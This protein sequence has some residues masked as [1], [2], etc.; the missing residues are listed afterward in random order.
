MDAEAVEQELMEYSALHA[1]RD[2]L[3]RRA[4]NAGIPLAR[5]AELMGVARSTIYRIG[6]RSGDESR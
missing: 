2:N 6:V 5:V 1:D 3:I 4:L